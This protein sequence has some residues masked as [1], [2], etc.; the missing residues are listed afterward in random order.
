MEGYELVFI[1]APGINEADLAAVLK[2]FKKN[3]KDSDGKLVHEYLWGHR[4]LAYEIDGNDFGVYHTW[5]FTGNGTTVN[6]LK[7]QFGYSDDVLRNQIVKTDDIDGDAAFFR[8]LM[9]TKDESDEKGSNE[10][11]SVELSKEI[12]EESDEGK[13]DDIKIDKSD[14]DSEEVV[15]TKSE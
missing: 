1:T 11:E 2:K 14:S 4:R 5:Y 6:E 15:E 8:E 3:L 7:R 13:I 9:I 12:D 10:I